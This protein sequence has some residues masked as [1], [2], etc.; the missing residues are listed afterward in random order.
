M[1][2]EGLCVGGPYRGRRMTSP[3]PVLFAPVLPGE[4]PEPGDNMSADGVHFRY[5][6]A[7]HY[8]AKARFG[9][10]IPEDETPDY[11]MQRLTRTYEEKY[12]RTH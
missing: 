12:G 11:L 8:A 6:F 4:L 10:W 7:L 9:F 3:T 5:Q 1:T 2:Y